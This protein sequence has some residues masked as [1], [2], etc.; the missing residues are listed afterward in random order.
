MVCFIDLP[1]ELRYLIAQYAGIYTPTTLEIMQFAY[2]RSRHE[3]YAKEIISLDNEEML[4]NLYALEPST[5]YYLSLSMKYDAV[6]CFAKMFTESNFDINRCFKQCIDINAF[7]CVTWLIN[8]QEV[9]VSDVVINMKQNTTSHLNFCNDLSLKYMMFYL[10]LSYNS[11][12]KHILELICEKYEDKIN[13][14]HRVYCKYIGYHQELLDYM[15]RRFTIVEVIDI[16]IQG[17]NGDY[18]NSD[19]VHYALEKNLGKLTLV[20]V[21][22]GFSDNFSEDDLVKILSSREYD[23]HEFRKLVLDLLINHK[24]VMLRLLAAGY[25]MD[26]YI[27]CYAVREKYPYES[28]AYLIE[29]GCHKVDRAI[30]YALNHR[31]ADIIKLFG[32][33]GFVITEQH[34]EYAKSRLKS[35]IEYGYK[36][37]RFRLTAIIVKLVQYF[38]VEQ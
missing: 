3:Q 29:L 27:L 21:K 34:I 25:K 5:N 2:C 37:E 30:R 8:T 32:D 20:S 33:N 17:V 9:D 36:D 23:I 14:D 31:G 10:C 19:I 26:N 15:S 11:D 16:L 7:K 13:S 22:W 6:S 28:I 4:E 35:A 24:N 18:W 38:D 1:A 12:N